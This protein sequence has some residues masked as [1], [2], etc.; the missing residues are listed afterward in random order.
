MIEPEREPS[1]QEAREQASVAQAWLDGEF[2]DQV[3]YP[4][5]YDGAPFKL[6]VTGHPPATATAVVDVFKPA[7]RVLEAMSRGKLTV[8]DHWGASVHRD[9]DGVGALKDGRSHLAPIYS[10]WDASA[11]RLAQG[12]QLPG[13]FANSE[14][15]TQVSEELCAQYFRADV[16]RQGI[17]MGRMKASGPYHLFSMAPIRTRHDFKSLRIGTTEGIEADVIRALGATAV[18]LSSLEMNPALSQGRV[19]A[20]HLAD[21]SAEVFGIGKVARFRTALGLVRQNLEFGMSKAAWTVLPPDLKVI[22]NAWLRAEAQA[23][24]QVFYRVAGARARERFRD[25]GMQFIEFSAA[26]FARVVEA[27]QSVGDAFVAK[28]EGEGRPARAMLT[29]IAKAAAHYRGKSASDLMREAI[30][31]PVQGIN[32]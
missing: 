24:T 2:V 22:L 25:G 21:G 4:I 15:A 29:D 20:M 18:T 6:I 1:W 26:D 16:E 9:R 31:N 17:L 30:F 7:F 28:E 13:L 19:D 5:G 11:Y 32:G 27:T 10:G 23:E 12:L 14:I 8:E 3:V